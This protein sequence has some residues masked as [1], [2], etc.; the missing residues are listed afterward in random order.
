M[1]IDYPRRG[2]AGLRHWLPSWRQLLSFVLLGTAAVAG[3]LVIL[4]AR[5]TVPAPNE[6]TTAQTT[7]VY[8]NDGKHELGRLGDA[9]RINV[10]LEQVPLN[11]QH[12][13]L[14]AEDRDFYNEGG[15]SPKG[16]GRAIWNNLSGGSLQGG[17]TITQQY[18]KNA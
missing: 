10:T 3:I 7:I 11:T 4:V 5:T 2:R 6:L 1:R 9:N 8:W 16:I 17:S 12:A 15:I 18:A 14:A 13:V